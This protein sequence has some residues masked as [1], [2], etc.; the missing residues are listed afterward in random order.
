MPE[1][2]SRRALLVSAGVVG[3]GFVAGEYL[4]SGGDAEEMLP[5]GGGGGG[6]LSGGSEELAV[7]WYVADRTGDIEAASDAVTIVTGTQ[8]GIHYGYKHM[9]ADSIEPTAYRA[10]N[11]N[12]DTSDMTLPAIVWVPDD[13]A[14]GSTFYVE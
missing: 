7:S 2:I 14:T 13:G 8:P 4:Q 11:R 10:D 3:A 1:K 6:L 9:S 12:F 5:A